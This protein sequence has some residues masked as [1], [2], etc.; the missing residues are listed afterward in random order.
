MGGNGQLDYFIHNI[1]F[2]V[3]RQILLHHQL[4]IVRIMRL[5][6]LFVK[7]DMNSIIIYVFL[8]VPHHALN[9][10]K[11]IIKIYVKDVLLVFKGNCYRFIIIVALVAP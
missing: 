7:V 3:W 1:F 8:I 11:K 5:F 10:T 4:Q 2:L 9:A 6:V